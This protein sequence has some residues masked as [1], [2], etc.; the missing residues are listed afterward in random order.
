MQD[1]EL[2]TAVCGYFMEFLQT[3][4]ETEDEEVPY[5]V[6]QGE[7]MAKMNMHTLFVRVASIRAMQPLHDSGELDWSPNDLWIAIEA[8]YLRLH[9][10]LR[11]TVRDFLMGQTHSEVVSIWARS[12]KRFDLA[13]HQL[14][15][16]YGIRDMKSALLGKLCALTG[17]V[18]RTSE[19]KPELLV[20]TFR[21]LECNHEIPQFRQEFKYSEPTVCPRAN[22]GGNQFEL[23]KR[24]KDT[25]FVDWQKIRLQENANEIPA[26]SMP[27][28]IDIIV[29]EEICDRCKPGDKILATGTLIVV[30]DVPA[31]F[32]PGEFKAVKHQYKKGQNG[33][34]GVRGLNALG[35]K[36]LNY[37]LCFLACFM[38]TDVQGG[39][40]ETLKVN[41]RSEDDDHFQ[42]PPSVKNNIM[43]M[44]NEPDIF[45]RLSKSICPSVVGHEDV[46]KGVLLMLMGGVPKRTAKENIK[47][48]GDVNVCIVG[49]PST[50][51]SQ[52]LKWVSG[53]LPRAVY[54]SGKSSSAAGLTASVV[55][56]ADTGEV[57]IEP[58]ALM[59]ADTGVCCIDEF[60]KMDHK[61]QVAIHEAME[62]QTISISKAGIQAT[63]NARTCILAAANPRYGRYDTT[64]TLKSNVDLTPPILSRFDLFYVED[65]T[66][67]KN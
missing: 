44:S 67:S 64:K 36:Q 35:Q 50:A 57:M 33:D 45:M 54:T 51:K 61:D 16:Y 38:D 43:E 2:E 4:R 3:Y 11:D 66:K 59:L 20:G 37:K 13:F 46:K 30:P 8:N 23:L 60:D 39:E 10:A 24:H 5:F 22:C 18:T 1:Q 42:L 48:R 47:L 49:D 32:K 19:V 55:R 7:Q 12:Q 31:L 62:Q 26:G 40:E 52:F 53:F 56:D 65:Q 34:D 15:W 63:L 6:Q 27:R 21:C 17:T 28:S 29:R 58:G 14:G 25:V 9:D 41:V